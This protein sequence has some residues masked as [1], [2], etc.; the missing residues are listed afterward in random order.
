MRTSVF[1]WQTEL[2]LSDHP[3]RPHFSAPPYRS[4]M[5]PVAILPGGSGFFL[6]GMGGLFYLNPTGPN[7]QIWNS[8]RM[9]LAVLAM[10]SSTWATG[11]PSPGPLNSGT[12]QFSGKSSSPLPSHA[13]FGVIS[14]WERSSSF[15]ANKAVVDIWA[16][17]TSRD[18][19]IMHLVRSIFFSAATNLYTVL[20][21]HIVGTN[22]SIADSLSRLHPRFCRLVP[23]VSAATLWHTA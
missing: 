10:A 22:N 11:L 17:G 2:C 14:G 12:D 7:C 6:L 15:T 16:S 18:P 20:V 13:F 4:L 3:R 21:T 19:L 1:D 5:K 9:P 8:S 23:T